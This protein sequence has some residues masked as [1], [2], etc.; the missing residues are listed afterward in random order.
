MLCFFIRFSISGIAFCKRGVI[1]SCLQKQYFLSLA[2][3]SPGELLFIRL[4]VLLF[5][6]TSCCPMIFFLSQREDLFNLPVKTQKK[7]CS[8][9][10]FGNIKIFQPGN[11]KGFFTMQVTA[12]RGTKN[13]LCYLDKIIKKKKQQVS[14]VN[15]LTSAT[16]CGLLSVLVRKQSIENSLFSIDCLLIGT[17]SLWFPSLRIKISCSNMGGFALIR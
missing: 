4:S 5:L 2:I 15:T 12:R 13:L 11:W 3:L 17:S 9:R 16:C 14:E 7:N 8:G 10:S 6:F 1:S